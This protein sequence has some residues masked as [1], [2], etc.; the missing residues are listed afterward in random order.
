MIERDLLGISVSDLINNYLLLYDHVANQALG[1]VQRQDV[2]KIDN[3]YG[4]D[5]EEQFIFV[6]IL[7][8]GTDLIKEGYV[9]TY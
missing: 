5:Y 3:E 9:L 8:G 1:I 6:D 2:E 4:M 7:Q